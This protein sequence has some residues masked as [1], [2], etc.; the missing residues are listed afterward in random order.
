MEL[1]LHISNSKSGAIASGLAGACRRAGIDWAVFLT[2]DGVR[3]LDDDAIASALKH[4]GTAIVCQDSWN[5]HM[6]GRSCPLGLGSQTSN[7]ALVSQ[8]VKAVSL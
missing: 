4:A 6:R 8:A 7:S 3:L 2:N 1:L 5:L